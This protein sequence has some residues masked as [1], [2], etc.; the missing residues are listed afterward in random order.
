M[1]VHWA[2]IIAMM[3]PLVPTHMV[4]ST[5]LVILDS[6]A[7]VSIAQVHF[8]EARQ[9]YFCMGISQVIMDSML[10]DLSTLT[11]YLRLSSMLLE[12]YPEAEY[13]Y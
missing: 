10:C 5:V 8:W 1:N 13:L 2:L 7:M 11:N 6:L 4:H 9:K 3:M 12:R